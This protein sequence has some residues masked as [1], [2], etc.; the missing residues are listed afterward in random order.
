MIKGLPLACVFSCLSYGFEGTGELFQVTFTQQKLRGLVERK[1]G[2]SN[3]PKG[4][5]S[6]SAE[7]EIVT[8]IY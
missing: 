3:Q 2:L 1:A 4:R 8:N 7:G 6:S 5:G